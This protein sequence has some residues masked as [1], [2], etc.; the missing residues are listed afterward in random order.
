MNKGNDGLFSVVFVIALLALVSL[1]CWGSNEGAVA[2]L[3]TQ[4]Y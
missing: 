4:G 1:A 2:P 3:V